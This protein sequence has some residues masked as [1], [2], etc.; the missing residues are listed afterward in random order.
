MGQRSN[1]QSFIKDSNTHQLSDSVSEAETLE[2]LQKPNQLWNELFPFTRCY[3]ELRTFF[4]S[5]HLRVRFWVLQLIMRN[6]SRLLELKIKLVRQLTS[7]KLLLFL[8]AMGAGCCYGEVA[9]PTASV[10]ERLNRN[11][12]QSSNYQAAN[13]TA[14]EQFM[15][16]D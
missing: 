7:Q 9:G 5:S 8:K 6:S 12:A 1:R 10:F 14:A 2:T 13:K 15:R 3:F 4:L 16:K 11:I